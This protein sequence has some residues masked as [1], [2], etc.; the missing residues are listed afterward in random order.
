MPSARSLGRAFAD[1]PVFEFLV[2]GLEPDERAPRH[3]AV[4]PGRHQ[5]TGP[6][7]DGVW[8]AAGGEGAALWAP[9]EHWQTPVRDGLA[10][11]LADHPGHPR[12]GVAAR[13]PCSPRV[14]KAHPREPHWYLA[15]LG[16]DPDHQG[17]GI[18]TAL[19]APVLER[20][21]REGMPAYLESSKESNVP[22][23]ERFGFRV[24]QRAEAARRAAPRCR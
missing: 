2:P 5:A 6:D 22:Y 9:P 13:W 16:T 12:P 14:E 20:C 21:D 24:T 10:L 17:K 15:V 19:L 8:T 3:H 1:D 7:G 18:G 4:L 23:Y 11:A